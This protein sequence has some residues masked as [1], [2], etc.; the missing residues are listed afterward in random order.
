M[1]VVSERYSY[2]SNARFATSQLFRVRGTLFG[3]SSLLVRIGVEF[4]EGLHGLV[5]CRRLLQIKRALSENKRTVVRALHY[6]L[7]NITKWNFTIKRGYFCADTCSY[8]SGFDLLCA[9]ECAISVWIAVQ[10]SELFEYSKQYQ[11]L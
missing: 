3:L 10:E 9:L 1:K 11:P 6:F 4:V 8:G 7:S 5:D 2:A